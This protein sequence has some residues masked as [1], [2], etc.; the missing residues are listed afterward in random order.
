MRCTVFSVK[1]ADL[2]AIKRLEKLEIRTSAARK[3]RAILFLSIEKQ[4][5]RSLSHRKCDR[6][7]GD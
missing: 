3:Q 5:K 2:K 7:A 1:I 4:A 6:L